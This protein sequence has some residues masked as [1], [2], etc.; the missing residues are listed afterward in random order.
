MVY[1]E[2]E[3]FFGVLNN[4]GSGCEATGEG[5]WLGDHPVKVSNVYIHPLLIDM[6]ARFEYDNHLELHV[7][8]MLMNDF[9]VI[10]EI[11]KY[12]ENQ[13]WAKEDEGRDNDEDDED[14]E[15]KEIKIQEKESQVLS[16]VCLF[17]YMRIYSTYNYG[18]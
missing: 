18:S 9:P 8:D 14:K 4:T 3:S 6:Y 13:D 2:R 15:E 1:T 5:L 16:E 12:R 11:V 17:W 7:F 10:E